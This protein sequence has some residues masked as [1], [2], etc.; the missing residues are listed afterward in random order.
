MSLSFDTE[1]MRS[2]A[3]SLHAVAPPAYADARKL[4]LDSRFRELHGTVRA[5]A[6]KT[7]TRLVTITT[8]SSQQ[9][10]HECR[11][12]RYS[13]ALAELADGRP[14]AQTYK[15]LAELRGFLG[16]F[17]NPGSPIKNGVTVITP[18]DMALLLDLLGGAKDF[19]SP[20][21][22]AAIAKG[23]AIGD[24]SEQTK[25]GKEWLEKH[26]I[27]R[28]LIKTLGAFT[29]V[30]TAADQYRNSAAQTDMG[31]VASALGTGGGS[32]AASWAGSYYTGGYGALL[33]AA[34]QASG[35]N[36]VDKTLAGSNDATVTNLERQFTGDDR[37]VKRYEDNARDGDY[38]PVIGGHQLLR[39]HAHEAPELARKAADRMRELV[40]DDARSARDRG[41]DLVRK[42]GDGV[43]DF[44]DDGVRSIRDRLGHVGHGGSW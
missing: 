12:L 41:P 37:S 17:V 3:T 35:L 10:D 15:D 23:G 13:A 27:V 33:V 1:K 43:R 39:D 26:A 18:A 14:D 31:R 16:K 44:V 32:A 42:A 38:G 24:A 9:I 7:I 19:I 36:L 5:H 29:A 28:G 6:A 22:E 4:S 2:C 21:L 11:A 34:D 20:L 40:E 25:A 8:L 30:A